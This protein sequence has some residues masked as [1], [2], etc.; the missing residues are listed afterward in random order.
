MSATPT[1]LE[2]MR[3]PIKDKV[4]INSTACCGGIWIKC[5]GYLRQG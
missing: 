3:G 2:V 5:N 4:G 1:P